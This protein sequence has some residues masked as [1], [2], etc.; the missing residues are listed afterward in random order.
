VAVPR[1]HKNAQ[2]AHGGRGDPTDHCGEGWHGTAPRRAGTAS[3]TN[4][5]S[6]R[7]IRQPCGEGKLPAVRPGPRVH[8]PRECGLP[9]GAR[10][11]RGERRGS[12]LRASRRMVPTL[13]RPW[14]RGDGA[15]GRGMSRP[16]PGWPP[17]AG[18]SHRRV[19]GAIR[20]RRRPERAKQGI[21]FSSRGPRRPPPGR[22]QRTMPTLRLDQYLL[23]FFY[24]TSHQ[25]VSCHTVFLEPPENVVLI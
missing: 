2:G 8:A 7:P 21:A 13:P 1:D 18:I 24:V 22:Q 25:K 23:F 14:V 20:T 17:L 5:A 15:P 12:E 9:A 16:G 6:A 4:V 11:G 19:P 10:R 3:F